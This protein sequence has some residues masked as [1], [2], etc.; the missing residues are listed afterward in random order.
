MLYKQQT[1]EMYTRA[2][3]IVIDNPLAAIP[4]ITFHEQYATTDGVAIAG[5]AGSCWLNLNPGTEPTP[6]D[7]VHPETGEAVGSMTY[8]EFQLALYSLYLHVAAKRD[9][10]PAETDMEPVDGPTD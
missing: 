9:E 8:G 3:S 10:P 6:F 2:S 5:R 7:L 4:N 1:T